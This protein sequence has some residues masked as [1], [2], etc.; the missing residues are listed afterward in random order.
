MFRYRHLIAVAGSLVFGGCATTSFAP[1]EVV[2]EKRDAPLFGDAVAD[3]D[4]FISKYR[5]STRS[6]ANG[7][8]YFEIPALLGV[9][10]S[11]TPVTFR[12]SPRRDH[13]I[14]RG[15]R[16]VEW[17]KILLCASHAAQ[18]LFH[19]DIRCQQ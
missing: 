14:G 15:R 1:P 16:I 6:T 9:V 13:R 8:Q 18:P 3:V 7:R 12:A 2:L 5:R 17:R 10:G 11:I 19:H 4:A